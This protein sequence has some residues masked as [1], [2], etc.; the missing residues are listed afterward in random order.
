MFK[1][2]RQKGRRGRK[3]K[4]KVTPMDAEGTWAKDIMDQLHKEAEAMPR[5]GRGQVQLTDKKL[6]R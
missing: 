6:L 5:R 2:A 4:P 1:V 3:L